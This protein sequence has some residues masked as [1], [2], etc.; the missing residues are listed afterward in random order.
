MM[1]VFLHIHRNLNIPG[2]L[3]T[4]SIETKQY[5]EKFGFQ[6]LG[7]LGNSS[8]FLMKLPAF[9]LDQSTKVIPAVS[10]DQSSPGM[11]APYRYK[12]IFSEDDETSC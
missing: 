5:F 3:W 6:D 9:V 10:I 12:S 11:K 4:E 7:N 8:E 2:S 1:E